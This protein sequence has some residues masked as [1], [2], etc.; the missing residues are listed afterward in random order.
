MN[1]TTIYTVVSRPSDVPSLLTPGRRRP[2]AR[3]RRRR[4]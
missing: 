4:P 2:L 3:R 1:P